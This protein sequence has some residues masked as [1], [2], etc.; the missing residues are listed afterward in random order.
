MSK[1]SRRMI[2]LQG[3]TLLIHQL[4]MFN[5]YM[6]ILMEP[7]LMWFHLR[8]RVYG[9]LM[10]MIEYIMN[11]ATVHFLFTNVCSLS[12]V[13]GYLSLILIWKLLRIWYWLCRN[14]ILRVRYMWKFSS[15][16]E[17]TWRSFLLSGRGQRLDGRR[18]RLCDSSCWCLRRGEREWWLREGVRDLDQYLPGEHDRCSISSITTRWLC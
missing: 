14:F 10:K 13:F 18:E 8:I 15:I 11:L 3:L 5:P 6:V 4:F 2:D 9:P 12:W 1:K 17:N 16:S 7:F